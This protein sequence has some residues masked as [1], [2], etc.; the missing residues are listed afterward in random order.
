MRNLMEY[1]L[2]VV[3]G[4]EEFEARSF[5]GSSL[6]SVHSDMLGQVCPAVKKV[7]NVITL[8]I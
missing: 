6:K 3:K 1:V 5:T 7:Q 8:P 2:A 4:L